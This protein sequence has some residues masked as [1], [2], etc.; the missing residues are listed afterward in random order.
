MNYAISI[1]LGL[2]TGAVLF[3][4]GFYFN[5]FVGQPMVSPLSVTDERVVDLSFSAVPSDAILY[6]DHG[7]SIITPRPERVAELWEP[8]VYD[9]DVF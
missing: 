8:A 6:T 4:G 1:G 5:P 3:I 2:L 7:E 9:T